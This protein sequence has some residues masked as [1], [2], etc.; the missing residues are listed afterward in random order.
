MKRKLALL[1]LIL[2]TGFKGFA[3][4]DEGMVSFTIEASSDNPEM[5]MVVGMMQ[6]ST[7]Q[8]YFTPKHARTVMNMGTMMN[9][10]S[11]IDES[12]GKCLT[13]MGGMMGNKAMEMTLEEAEAKLAAIQKP[14]VTL[15]DESKEVVGIICKKAILTDEA[16]A[17]SEVWYTQ[18]FNVS[19][20]GQNFMTNQYPGFPLQF[21]MTNNGI[22]MIMTAKEVRKELSKSEKKE[23]FDLSIPEGYQLVTAEDF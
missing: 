15:V 6:G 1:F 16:G 21:T 12:A 20:R 5:E 18:E 13:L 23:L 17:E 4:V 10:T 8:M 19:A 14:K 2:V 22:K 9:V 11:I 3:Q 7:M